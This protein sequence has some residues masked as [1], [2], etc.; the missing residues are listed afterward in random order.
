MRC[1]RPVAIHLEAL[2]AFDRPGLAKS[3]VTTL[4]AVNRIGRQVAAVPGQLCC[5]ID[6]KTVFTIPGQRAANTVAVGGN[7][8]GAIVS[9][10]VTPLCFGTAMHVV[11]EGAADEFS[12][13]IFREH[14][15]NAA[16][17]LICV[18]LIVTA[19]SR[20][21]R[22]HPVMSAFYAYPHAICLGKGTRYTATIVLGRTVPIIPKAI[23]YA[24]LQCR[25]AIQA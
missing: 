4:K 15:I 3:I 7:I 19:G 18:V 25:Q 17:H 12:V 20:V 21:F 10:A 8:P 22:C 14:G 1:Y 13:A 5:A 23:A 24:L 6:I 2:A 9:N 16:L 11:D